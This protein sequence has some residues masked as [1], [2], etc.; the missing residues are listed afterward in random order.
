[1]G[2]SARS[3]GRVPPTP[4]VSSTVARRHRSGFDELGEGGARHRD[5]AEVEF[6]RI[7]AFSDGVFAIAITLL[8]LGLTI[9]G[10]ADDL[11]RT[12]LNQE[13]DLLAYAISFAVVGRLWIGHHRF[14]AALERFDGSLMGL[15][16]IYL[17]FL[18]LI[19]FTSQVLGDYGG[20]RPAVIL[21][22]LN[23]ALVSL[24]FQAQIVYAY[25]SGLVWP[26]AREFE[27]RMAGPANFLVA[28]VFLVSIPV[29]F[30]STTV[31]TVM[32]IG[33]FVVGA[34]LED[35]VARLRRGRGPRR[36]LTTRGR[37]DE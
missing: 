1:M 28:T 3:P 17:A 23:M 9:P 7:V 26:D 32:W 12:L 31:A 29:A 18:V 2:V 34:R 19:P 30:L 5:E 36:R 21:Y 20:Q 11:T 27:R 13:G 15:N 10:G 6:N 16:L 24:S 25:R 35:R 22:A 33:V 37:D 14:F 4:G 8:V